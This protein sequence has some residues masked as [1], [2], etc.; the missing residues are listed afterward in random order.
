[1]DKAEDMQ[2]GKERRNIVL[3]V[4]QMLM[5]VLFVDDDPFDDDVNIRRFVEGK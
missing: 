5:I 3:I 2:V 1:M 4:A